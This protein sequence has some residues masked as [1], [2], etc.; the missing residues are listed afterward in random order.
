MSGH[1]FAW[2]LIS[3]IDPSI[4]LGRK[5]ELTERHLVMLR[6]TFNHFDDDRDGA[7]T[8]PQ[9]RDALQSLGFNTRDKFLKRF[10]INP[11]Q[12]KIHGQHSLSFKTDFKTFVQVLGKE[13]ESL[14]NTELEL[15]ALFAFVDVNETGQLSRKELRYLLVDIASPCRLSQQEFTRFIKGLVFMSDTDSISIADLKKHVLFHL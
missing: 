2:R 15:D 1:T 6:G 9:L 8:V 4:L 12:L 3:S 10:C 5:M 13:L 7:L 14:H 11:S